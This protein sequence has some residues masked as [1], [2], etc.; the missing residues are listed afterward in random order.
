MK[1]AVAYARYSTDKQTENSIAFQLEAIQKYCVK[2]NLLLTAIFKDDAESGTNTD[3]EGFLAMLDAARRKEFD[4][5]VIYDVTRGS[6]DVADWFAFRKA[7]YMLGIEVVS[8]TEQLGDITDPNN[9]LTELITIGI[10]Q[11][12]VLTTRQKSIAGVAV[13]AKQGAFLGGYP[14]LGYDIINGQ[15]VINEQEARTVRMIF[16]AYA[17][18]K[19]YNAI[20]ELIHGAKGKRGRPIGKN[21]L[22]SILTNER[23]IGVYTWN[24]RFQKR[25]RKWAGGKPNPNCVRIENFIPAII[26]SELWER[27][28]KRMSE[29]KRKAVNKAKHEYLLSGLIECTNCGSTYVGHC[30]TNKKGYSTRY[31]ICG[32]K[33]RTRTCNSK[34]INADEIE[35]FVVQQLKAYLLETDFEE[36][37]QYIADQVNNTSPD[38]SRE[39]K[40]L[41]EITM[42]ISNGMKAILQGLDFTELKDEI[43]RLQIRKSELEDIIARNESNRK[44]VDKNKIIELFRHSIENWDVDLKNIIKY[45]ITKIYANI[46]GSYTVNVGVHI[47]GCGGTQPIVC[48][49]FLYNKSIAGF[50][51]VRN[52]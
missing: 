12:Q 3:R 30:S 42:Q 10:G 27:V 43:S 2:N 25:F 18:G 23:Y 46:D 50:L 31:Y 8:A 35:T 5:V 40:E 29:N 34:N 1:K 19:S 11:H 45:H 32:N 13:K 39:K 20:L 52:K 4:C 33:Y 28:Q 49:T 24:K 38:L 9:F 44:K 16:E 22:H 21:S 47:A 17:S 6:R 7:M 14:P 51:K 36:I 48:T 15:Y 41:A 26:G 37:A